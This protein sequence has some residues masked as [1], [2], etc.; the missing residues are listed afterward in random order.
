MIF[1][2]AMLS[3]EGGPRPIARLGHPTAR[4]VRP[5]SVISAGRSLDPSTQDKR[6]HL[7]PRR[8]C[9]VQVTPFAAARGNIATCPGTAMDAAPGSRKV[10]R[11]SHGD[12]PPDEGRVKGDALRRRPQTVIRGDLPLAG[13]L[14]LGRLR[15][16]GPRGAQFE[17]TLAATA[18][19]LRRLAKLMARPPPMVTACVA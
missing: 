12:H 13:I 3:F 18:Q 16:R 5:R 11:R 1:E 17:F 10:S 6:G 15:L 7:R 4:P 8:P 2:T 19:N 9:R 14:H